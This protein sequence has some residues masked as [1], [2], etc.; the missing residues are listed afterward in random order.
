MS[1]NRDALKFFQAYIKEMIDLGGA[2]LPKSISASLGAKLAKLLLKKG[3][4]SLENSLKR[5]YNALNAKTTIK[6]IDDNTLEVTLKYS[7]KFCPIGGKYNPDKSDLIQNTICIPY[8]AA[9]LKSSH[10]EFKYSAEIKECILSSNNRRC[11]YILF[12]EPKN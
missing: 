9:I 6:T 10:P 1:K 12:K 7:K 2:N 5:I 11:K 3:V 8:T 4:T